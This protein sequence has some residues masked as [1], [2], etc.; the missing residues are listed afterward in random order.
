MRPRVRVRYLYLATYLLGGCALK[1]HAPGLGDVPAFE[2]GFHAFPSPR[3][4]DGPGTV[5]RVGP[6]GVRHDVADLSAMVATHPMAEVI[7]RISVRGAFDVGGFIAWLGGGERGVEY[8][9][10]DSAVVSVSGAK[11][12]QAYEASLKLVVDSAMQLIDWTKP[13]RVYLITETI[14]ADS[15][16]IDVGSKAAI[17]LGDTLKS[18]SAKSHG[19]SVGW[20]PGQSTH[21]ALRFAQPMRVFYKASQLVRRQ[22]FEQDSIPPLVM[23][24]ASKD[25]FW[26]DLP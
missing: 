16:S 15:V 22:G 13:G 9:E 10:S 6:D 1:Y 4:F 8:S 23:V 17:V 21:L 19:V 26:R 5:F 25:L 7:P 3:S 24:P 11:R 12:E 2:A 14:L 20:Q 18:D